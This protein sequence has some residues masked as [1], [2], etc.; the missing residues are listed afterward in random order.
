MGFK[1][2]YLDLFTK[3]PF[4]MNRKK[5]S[6]VEIPQYSTQNCLQ[7]LKVEDK[8]EIKIR[9][10]STWFLSVIYRKWNYRDKDNFL[11]KKKNNGQGGSIKVNKYSEWWK[12]KNTKW[13]WEK[14]FRV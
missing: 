8:M 2:E 13:R 9:T 3:S 14:I 10:I 12:H 5:L 1:N 6:Y 7:V 11:M 4:L